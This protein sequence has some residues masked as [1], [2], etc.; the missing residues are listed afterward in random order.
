MVAG[1]KTCWLELSI[2]PS[3]RTLLPPKTLNDINYA[4]NNLPPIYY[5]QAA[6]D[7]R[8]GFLDYLNNWAVPGCCPT[9]ECG[10]DVSF[11]TA[12]IPPQPVQVLPNPLVPNL[13]CSQIY[14]V[15]EQVPTLGGGTLNRPLRAVLAVQRAGKVYPHHRLTTQVT[16][17]ARFACQRDLGIVRCRQGWIEYDQNCYYPPQVRSCF[18]RLTMTG[19]RR[20][21]A[22]RHRHAGRSS[23]GL[24]RWHGGVDT[25]RARRQ[26]PP[27]ARRLLVRLH[28]PLPR[29]RLL[30]GRLRAQL[31]LLHVRQQRH[32]RGRAGAL[33]VRERRLPGPALPLRRLPGALLADVDVPAHA[34]DFN[35]RA[36]RRAVSRCVLMHG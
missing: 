14:P 12:T 6:C 7:F 17:A 16:G 25:H 22:Q 35:Q 2:T 26:V 20:R 36:G 19:L 30:G 29:L 13:T 27:L 10:G 4:Q 31:H 8:A 28:H 11:S 18:I 5:M 3:N 34:I 32:R 9:C 1:N 24:H 21:A 15:S 23:R 33:L